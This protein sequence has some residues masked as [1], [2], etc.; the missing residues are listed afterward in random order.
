MSR[1]NLLRL[2]YLATPAFAALDVAL[3]ATF[4]AAGIESLTWRLVYYA[5]AFG[6]WLAIR[7][8]PHW[9][10]FVGIGESSVNLLLLLLS[11]L[12]PIFAAPAMVAEGGMP[13]LSFGIW[14]ILNFFLSGAILVLSFQGHQ[15]EL[16]Q[17]VGLGGSAGRESSHDESA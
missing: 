15:N 8:R 9:T 16:F 10:P 4:R 11:V 7:Q 14:R 17:R 2:Y 1:A 5:F 12:G 3:G 13:D 6:C